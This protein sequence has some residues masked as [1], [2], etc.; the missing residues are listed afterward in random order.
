MVS[1]VMG[2]A[3]VALPSA[4]ITAGLMDELKNNPEGSVGDN[5]K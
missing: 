3:V 5:V 2:I 4:I 1:S